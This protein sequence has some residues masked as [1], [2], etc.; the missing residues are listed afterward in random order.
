MRHHNT[1]R[2]LGRETGQRG[3]LLKSLSRSLVIRGSMQTTEAR[4][5]ETRKVLEKLV[6]KAKNPTLANHRAIV[7]ALGDE[8]AA[9]KLIKKAADYAERPGGYLRIVKMGPRKGDASPMALIEFV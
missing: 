1:N 9:K 3:A 5:K 4:A 6:T 2:K 8:T 7:S